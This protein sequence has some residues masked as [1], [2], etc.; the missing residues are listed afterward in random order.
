MFYKSFAM[1]YRAANSADR[2]LLISH[3]TDPNTS[4]SSQ[5]DAYRSS[6]LVEH[7]GVFRHD[8]AHRIIFK[9]LHYTQKNTQSM[10]LQW[11]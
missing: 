1:F 4:E 10:K 9:W 3:N 11:R 2:H 6:L 7:N 8:E 5:A